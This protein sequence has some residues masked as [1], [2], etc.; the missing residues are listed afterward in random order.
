MYCMNEN[1]CPY[2]IFALL[3]PFITAR[4]NLGLG[5]FFYFLLFFKKTPQTSQ[6]ESKTQ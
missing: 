3:T 5:E 6:G 2:F 4:A 1:I